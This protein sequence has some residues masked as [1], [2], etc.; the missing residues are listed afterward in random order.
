MCGYLREEKIAKEFIVFLAIGNFHRSRTWNRR[1]LW[2][3]RRD[4][5]RNFKK[6]FEIFGRS[7]AL[8]IPKTRCVQFGTPRILTTPLLLLIKTDSSS[9]F[10]WKALISLQYKKKY[11][12]GVTP[13]CYLL[14]LIFNSSSCIHRRQLFTQ[15]NVFVQRHNFISVPQLNC[16]HFVPVFLVM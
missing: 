6:N 9:L 4:E 5:P 11:S 14:V 2:I 16:P 8:W 1:N 15:T 3:R 10:H 12:V 7:F 13:R